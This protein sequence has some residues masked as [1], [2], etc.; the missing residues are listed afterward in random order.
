MN[1]D[2]TLTI[3]AENTALKAEVISLKEQLS[4]L[5][6]QI[7]GQKS[8]RVIPANDTQTALE[9]GS[10]PSSQ[11]PVSTETITY[12][13]KS[14]NANK[15]PHGRDEIP[16]HIPRVVIDIK[17]D[18]DTA[19]M[20]HISD[21]VTEQ[22]EYKAPEFYVKQYVR[23]VHASIENGVRIIHC[24][25]LPSLCIEKGKLGPTVVAHTILS[26]CQ[27]HLPH[28]RLAKMMSRD[29]SMTIPESTIR[30]AF[31]QGIFL[32]DAIGY[33]LKEIAAKSEYQQMDE[34]TIKVLISMV[35]G[36]THLG[37]MWVRHAP[38]EKIVLFDYQKTRNIERGKKLLENFHGVLQTDGLGLYPA[39]SKGL[40]LT[41]AGCMDHCRRGFEE[42]LTND[43]ARST[44]AI[45]LIRPLYAVE[46]DARERNLNHELR[47]EMRKEKSIPLFNAL[48]EW[49]DKNIKDIRPKS[50]F[51]KAVI[52]LIERKTELGH[53][54]EDGRI[55]MSNIL[56]ENAI[57]PLAIGRKN[58]L[59][60]GSE[61]GACRLATAYT[62]IATCIKNEINVRTYLNH[63]LEE[64][65]KRLSKNI[66]DLLPLAGL[67][68]PLN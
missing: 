23:P 67:Y 52:Y 45:D 16:A 26:K 63:V 60:A 2:D 27:D 32:L 38:L 37:Y 5:K 20:E 49:A 1:S 13:R 31:R 39:I 10:L 35:K 11:A 66:D 30:D 21:K 33:R 53:F 40:G 65:P 8:E 48:V 55:E 61:E 3:L 25:E 6:R 56:V 18:Y 22:L 4:W 57:R 12:T 62:I 29:C 59:F 36:K 19:E 9:L 50:P 28:Y 54:L 15:T 24:P 64:I 44:Q 41:H 46:E 51:G 43:K 34:S 7:F 14:P 17:P 58:Y 47:L 42:A 68:L